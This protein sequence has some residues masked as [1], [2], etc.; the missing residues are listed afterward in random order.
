MGVKYWW[1]T[2]TTSLNLFFFL[3]VLCTKVSGIGQEKGKEQLSKVQANVGL[4]LKIKVVRISVS[5]TRRKQISVWST[6]VLLFPHQQ[7]LTFYCW[8]GTWCKP[9]NQWR[10]CWVVVTIIDSVTF[11]EGWVCGFSFFWFSISKQGIIGLVFPTLLMSGC[12]FCSNKLLH[13]KKPAGLKVLFLE[14]SMLR[15]SST[16][17]ASSYLKNNDKWRAPWPNQYLNKR[18]LHTS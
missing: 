16:A 12:S 7:D 4:R 10:Q 14:P 11:C 8:G 3:Y 5:Q 1:I 15:F 13:F 2:N 17:T 18:H 6:V 9:Q